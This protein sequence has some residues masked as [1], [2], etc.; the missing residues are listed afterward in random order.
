MT[1]SKRSLVALLLI[2]AGAVQV[3]SNVGRQRSPVAV[4]ARTAPV[5]VGDMAPDFTL[6][7]QR[8]NTITLAKARGRKAVVL[9]FYRGHW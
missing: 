7:D 3:E 6:E 1:K 5:E 8:G 2:V 9:L 4:E